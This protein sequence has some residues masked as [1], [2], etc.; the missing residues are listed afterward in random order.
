MAW[1]RSRSVRSGLR[2]EMAVAVEGEAN[3][4]VPGPSC[5]LLGVGSGGDPERDRRM[6]KVVDANALQP[7]SVDRRAPESAAEGR[8]PE[9]ATLGAGEHEVLGAAQR[10]HALGQRLVHELGESHCATGRPGL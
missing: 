3:G 2:V 5:Y 8:N 9:H 6:T 1:R 7:R 10:A 4:G